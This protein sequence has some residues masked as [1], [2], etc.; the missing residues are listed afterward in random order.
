MPAKLKELTIPPEVK[1]Q[2]LLPHPTLD[3]CCYCH[4][5]ADN[6]AGLSKLQ[7]KHDRLWHYKCYTEWQRVQLYY[8][9]PEL[10]ELR[11]PSNQL[12]PDKWRIIAL[13]MWDYM[14]KYKDS[15]TCKRL[16]E[17]YDIYLSEPA[18]AKAIRQL[19]EKGIIK[20]ENGTCRR[21]IKKLYTFLVPKEKLYEL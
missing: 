20:I 10:L 9:K 4:Q 16:I 12:N 11:K 14:E 17:E 21:G 6:G 1:Q 19:G 5:H 13:A 2:F 15:P 18:T 8:V 3:K 7:T